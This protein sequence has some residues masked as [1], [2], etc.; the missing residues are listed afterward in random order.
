MLARVENGHNFHVLQM[1][2][3]T[4]KIILLKNEVT[5]AKAFDALL[6]SLLW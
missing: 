6:V 5:D 4:W 1:V 3:E 2:Q